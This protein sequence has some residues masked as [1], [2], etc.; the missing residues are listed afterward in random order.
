MAAATTAAIIAAS[1][2]S[3][4]AVGTAAYSAYESHEQRKDAK[5]ATERA[6]QEARDARDKLAK[7][8][9]AALELAAAQVEERKR[10]I[11]RNKQLETGPLGV[12][13]GSQKVK[14]ALGQ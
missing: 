10:A 13:Q 12:E 8:E 7:D 4:A 11:A 3:V 1:V 6:E 2:A 9:A 14:T 5:K